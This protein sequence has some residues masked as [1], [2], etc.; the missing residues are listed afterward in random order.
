LF[1]SL[2]VLFFVVVLAFFEF[3][4]LRTHFWPF[5]GVQNGDPRE[6][7]RKVGCAAERPRIMPVSRIS[8]DRMN[9][10]IRI[11]DLVD[12]VHYVNSVK[13]FGWIASADPTNSSAA[14]NFSL[15]GET[16]DH[17]PSPDRYG[18][19]AADITNRFF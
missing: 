6:V 8:S 18:E 17:P 10:I 13:R 3:S 14:L 4:S 11:K 2:S 7:T 15:I 9:R 5:S 12:S 1:V 16:T 19:Q